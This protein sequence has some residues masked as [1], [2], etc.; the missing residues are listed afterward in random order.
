LVNEY[1]VE[2]TQLRV[3]AEAFL[4]ELQVRG[5]LEPVQAP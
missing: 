2:R 5:L 1:D 3:D 4:S